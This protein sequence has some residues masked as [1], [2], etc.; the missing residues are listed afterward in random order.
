MTSL[1]EPIGVI[2]HGFW[3]FVREAWWVILLL[4]L[5]GGGTRWRKRDK[6]R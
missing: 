2:L 3:I 4:W 5:V 1:P 6:W